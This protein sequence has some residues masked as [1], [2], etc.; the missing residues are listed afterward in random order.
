MSMVGRAPVEAPDERGRAAEAL[1]REVVA[2]YGAAPA[3]VRVA[4]APYR[5]CPIGAHI[6]HQRGP[7]TAMALD[8]G[9]LLAFAPSPAR[10]VRLASHDFTAGLTSRSLTSLKLNAPRQS[11]SMMWRRSSSRIGGN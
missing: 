11:C 8:R 1:R 7:V 2:R 9:I 3:S 5:V 4:R 10:E 6:D